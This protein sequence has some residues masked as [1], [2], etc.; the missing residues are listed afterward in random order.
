MLRDKL[1]FVR[2]KVF[3]NIANLRL[4]GKLPADDE[5]IWTNTS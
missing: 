1:K 5:L 4:L 3:D 2:K